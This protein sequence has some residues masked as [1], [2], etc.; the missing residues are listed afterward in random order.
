MQITNV[1]FGIYHLQFAPDG[2]TSYFDRSIGGEGRLMRVSINGGTAV[3]ISNTD[4]YLWAISPD[5]K[6]NGL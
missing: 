3:S 4:V 5:G 6:K 2:L 1:E